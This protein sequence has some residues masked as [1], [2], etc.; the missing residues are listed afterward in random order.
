MRG[1]PAG[2]RGSVPPAGRS[3]DAGVAAL[4]GEIGVAESGGAEAPS[5]AGIPLQAIIDSKADTQNPVIFIG[6]T[7]HLPHS[8]VPS[9]LAGHEHDDHDYEY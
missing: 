3:S 8:E 5:A 2:T 4:D 9:K 1:T 7:S 6:P